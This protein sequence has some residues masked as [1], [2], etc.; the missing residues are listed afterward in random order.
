[1]K[2]F[3]IAMLFLATLITLIGCGNPSNTNKQNLKWYSLKGT[4]TIT[5]EDNSYQ[6]VMKI[7]DV[8]SS[9]TVATSL[10]SFTISKAGACFL[11]DNQSEQGSV[12]ALTGYFDLPPQGV[13]IGALADPIVKGEITQIALYFVEADQYGSYAIYQ[14]KGTVTDGNMSG[15]FS[16]VTGS[17]NQENGSF[18]GMQN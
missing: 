1:M 3:A 18:T 16:C 12:T 14:G 17:C 10:G 4:W 13:L 5:T 15:T 9:C 7:V 2:R 6:N 11:A 8:P